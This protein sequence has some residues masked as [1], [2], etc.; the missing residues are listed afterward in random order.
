MPG[1]RLIGELMN[2]WGR[3]SLRPRDANGLPSFLLRITLAPYI[4]HPSLSID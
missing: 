2:A 1:V 4:S 3:S